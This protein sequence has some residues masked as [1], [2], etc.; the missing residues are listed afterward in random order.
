M[1][2]RR[3]LGEFEDRQMIPWLVGLGYRLERLDG[4]EPPEIQQII[5]RL[6]EFEGTVIEG[7]AWPEAFRAFREGPD[8][9]LTVYPMTNQHSSHS[10]A[11][12]LLILKNPQEPEDNE[13]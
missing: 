6:R 9:A 1:A 10:H 12:P 2:E 3:P 11:I 4:T 5:A 7:W 8:Y 13:N